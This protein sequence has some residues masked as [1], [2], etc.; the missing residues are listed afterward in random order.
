MKYLINKFY[1]LNA[2]N[3]QYEPKNISYVIFVLFKV[4]VL[5]N[6]LA[7]KLKGL[8]PISFCLI[9]IKVNIYFNSTLLFGNIKQNFKI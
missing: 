5:H 3:E 2:F 1:F 6:N 8:L 9:K 7:F 4:I